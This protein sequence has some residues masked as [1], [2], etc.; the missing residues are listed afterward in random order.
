MGML[1]VLRTYRRYWRAISMIGLLLV[2]GAVFETVSLL[3][4]VPIAT[5]VATGNDELNR[6]IVGITLEAEAVTL[7]YVAIGAVMAGL[8]TRL[9]TVY[10]QARLTVAVER[11]QR[12]RIY[13]GF[14]HATWETQS[15]EPPGRFQ[16]ASNLSAG[17]AN[18]LSTILNS[19]KFVINLLTMLVAAVL[20]SP[21]G[22]F[23]ILSI[24]FVLYLA[25]QPLLRAAKR[26]NKR[27]L[28]AQKAQNVATAEVVD[29]AG[30]IKA[31]GVTDRFVDRLMIRTRGVLREK[32]V[33]T[34]LSG[35]IPAIYQAT[36]LL[37]ALGILAYATVQPVDF[38]A[39]GAVALLL[40]RSLGSAQGI[41]TALVRYAELRPVLDSLEEWNA[42]YAVNRDVPGTQSI[43]SVDAV[44]IEDICFEYSSG[45]A[46]VDGV[47]VSLRPG[48]DLGIVGPSGAGK[49]TVAQILLRF[50]SPSRGRYLVNGMDAR[51][52]SPASFSREVAY[53]PQTPVILRGTVHDNIAMFRD[54]ISRADVLAAAG[55]AG[56]GP[57][58]STLPGGYDTV[59][60]PD[61]HGF[62]GGQA[63]RLSIARALAGTPSL[64]ILDE[65][66]SALDVDSEELVTAALRGLPEHVIVVL[67]AHRM[68]TLRHCNR[69]VVLEDGRMTASG[70]ADEILR[71]NAFFQR[72]VAAGAFSTSGS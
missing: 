45:T 48:D 50:R 56:L 9:L 5:A 52:I 40:L 33:A 30:Q 37:I 39:L 54:G 4:L 1:G 28:R 51:E 19:L 71:D 49:S 69:I 60:G 65:P 42:V 61:T 38:P 57:W 72:A 13:G 7:V 36:A 10:L 15:A 2:L 44:L 27:M 12:A 6:T 53:V 22:A 55:Q 34:L 16:W 20:V 35:V 63:Q 25:L 14:L 18:L 17:Y 68:S 3:L 29:L 46:A 64:V 8:A 41:Q 11:D 24:A 59:I 62:S 32:R 26:A 66:T 70:T 31:Y 23:T 43:E 47:T 67:I 58:I 21:T